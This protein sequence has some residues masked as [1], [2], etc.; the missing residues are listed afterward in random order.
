MTTKGFGKGL[1]TVLHGR[2]L[3][4]AEAAAEN[5]HAPY[6]G[7][8][9]GAAVLGGRGAVYTGA[10]IEN[11]SYGLGLCAERAALAVARA[12][13]ERNIVAVAVACVDA[14]PDAPLEQ[15]MPCGACLQWIR[16]LAP[17]AE[18]IVSGAERSFTLKDLLPLGFS[19]D[20]GKE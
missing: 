5:A 3:A 18:I 17:G 12:A 7:F 20:S 8:R 14:P 19:L 2:L 6:S 11:A 4:Q 10:N 13:G 15:R 16:E 9:V 1:D